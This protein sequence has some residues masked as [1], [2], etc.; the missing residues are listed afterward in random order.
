MG[1]RRAPRGDD[2]VGIVCAALGT[3]M[4]FALPMSWLSDARFALRSLLRTPAFAL[5]VILTLAIG[6]GANTAIFSV[7]RGVLLRPLPYREP[8]RLVRIYDRWNDFPSGS[9]SVPELR[10]YRAQAS[11]LA[12]LAAW[13]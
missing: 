4:A 13:G 12:G 5:I 11:S 10:D 6:V 9:V 3:R 8:E 2:V 7:V 1:H